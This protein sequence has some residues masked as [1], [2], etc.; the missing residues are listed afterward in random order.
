MFE[1]LNLGSKLTSAYGDIR[2]KKVL[3]RIL[4]ETHI[5]L[6]VRFTASHIFGEGKFKEYPT[7]LAPKSLRKRESQVPLKPQ[8]PVMRTVLPL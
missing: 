7:T 2:D 8:L 3:S 6:F 5:I 1:S 4:P